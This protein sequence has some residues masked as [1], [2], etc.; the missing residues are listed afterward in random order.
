MLLA[1]TGRDGEKQKRKGQG[2]EDSV[3]EWRTPRQGL[4]QRRRRRDA[5]YPE[6]TSIQ[7]PRFSDTGGERHPKGV[8]SRSFCGG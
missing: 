4:H 7:N 5:G 2:R 6:G 1:V 8:N 3:A